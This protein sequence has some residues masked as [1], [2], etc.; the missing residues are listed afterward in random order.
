MIR[1]SL[2][3]LM[4]T[5]AVAF[6]ATVVLSSTANAQQYPPSENTLVLSVNTV[7]QG[8]TLT[9]TAQIFP[10]GC[11]VT[12]TLD[13]GEVL[14]TATAD[15]SGVA[16]LT[17]TIPASTSKGRHTVTA[18]GCSL[19]LSA[20][21]T[22]IDEHA[23]VRPTSAGGALART[24]DDSSV[25]LTQIGLAGVAAGGLLVLVARKRRDRVA[26]AGRS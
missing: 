1:R 12:F 15:A 22:V 8:G 16:T 4:V 2:V 14:G 5:T 13:T 17:A 26:V 10:A 3:A 6:L 23:I 24:G 21:F 20:S 11:V 25:P 9:L 19:V 7:P 18:T